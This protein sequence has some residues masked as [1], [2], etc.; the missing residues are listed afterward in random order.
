MSVRLFC[1]KHKDK[2]VMELKGMRRAIIDNEVATNRVEICSAIDVMIKD[3]E[4]SSGGDAEENSYCDASQV[5]GPKSDVDIA[6]R[7]VIKSAQSKERGIEF[8]LTFSEYKRLMNKKRCCYTG[9][10]LLDNCRSQHPRKRTIDRI[11]STGP[12]SKANCVAASMLS[13]KLKNELFENPTQHIR[14]DIKTLVAF[15]KSM[16]RMHKIINIECDED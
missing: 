1:V 12:Y 9:V 4:V 5:S 14:C 3:K 16:V 11:D 10:V 15:T 7:Y 6:Q 13:N 8:E 2:T